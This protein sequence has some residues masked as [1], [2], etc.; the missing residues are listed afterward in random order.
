MEE[1]RLEIIANAGTRMRFAIAPKDHTEDDPFDSIQQVPERHV[2]LSCL[3]KGLCYE[4]ISRA[5]G[6]NFLI[7][8]FLYPT[9]ADFWMIWTKPTELLEGTA[10]ALSL[11]CCSLRII[12]TGQ[13]RG[14]CAPRGSCWGR[15]MLLCFRLSCGL[16]DS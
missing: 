1:T 6:M 15:N 9:P 8:V 7:P 4:C 3:E 5:T 12:C 10:K 2:F 14:L 16:M 11:T 13:E